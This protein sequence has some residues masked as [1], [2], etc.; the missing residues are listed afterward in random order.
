M[1]RPLGCHTMFLGDRPMSE[2][3]AGVPKD[4][5]DKAGKEYKDCLKCAADVSPH[6]M[7]HYH[8]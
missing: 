3:G 5:F 6:A 7:T 2:R 1:T 4:A 8:D